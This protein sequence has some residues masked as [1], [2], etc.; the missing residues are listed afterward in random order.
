LRYIVCSVSE[1]CLH[2]TSSFRF[3]M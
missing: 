3:T 2:L 1:L